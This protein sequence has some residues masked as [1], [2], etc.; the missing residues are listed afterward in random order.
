MPKALDHSQELSEIQKNGSLFFSLCLFGV[1]EPKLTEEP[2]LMN[3][4]NH[5]FLRLISLY[6]ITPIKSTVIKNFPNFPIFS[7]FNLLFLN[8]IRGAEV[9]ISDYN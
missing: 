5:K 2:P 9:E 3:P 8:F 6:A 4:K 1:S 7:F